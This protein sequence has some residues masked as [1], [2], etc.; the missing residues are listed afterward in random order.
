MSSHSFALTVV[1]AGHKI[2]Q[3]LAASWDTHAKRASMFPLFFRYLGCFVVLCAITCSARLE[4][5]PPQQSVILISVDT[6]RA[7]HLGCYGYRAQPTPNIDRLA[8]GGTLFGQASTQAPL[9][10]PSHVSLFTSRY[11]FRTQIQDNGEQLA[12]GAVTLATQFKAMGYRTAAFVG[13]FPLDRRFGLAQGFDVYDSPF[14]LRK[15]RGGDTGDIKRPAESVV[16]NATHWIEKNSDGPFFVFLHLYDLHTPYDLPRALQLRFHGVSYDSEL[17]YVD[18]TLGTFWKFLADR[19][20]FDRSLLIFTSDHGEGL[21]EHG[22]STHGYFIYQSTLHVPLIVHWPAD[23]PKFRERVDEPVELIQ[24]APTILQFAGAK[25]PLE[26]EGRVLPARA[27]GQSTP[28]DMPIYGESYYASRHFNCSPLRSIRLGA[29]KY[30]DA[31][32]PEL[33]DLGRDPTERRNIYT[34]GS[35]AAAILRKKLRQ[36]SARREALK[37]A[38]QG[39]QNQDAIAALRSLGYLAGGDSRSTSVV[40]GIDPKDRLLDFEAQNRAV[41]LAYSGRLQQSNAVLE[42]LIQ[43]LPDIPELRSSLGLNLQRLGRHAEAVRVFQEVV[44]QSESNAVAHFNLAVSYYQMRQ[45]EPSIQSLQKAL[46]IEPYYTRAE[47]LLGTIWSQKKDYTRARASFEHILKI[48]PD[49]Y[50]A[51]FNLGVLAAIQGKWD[52]GESHLR[53]VLQIDPNSAEAY[54][55]LGS[56]YLGRQDLPQA[57]AAFSDAIR[58]QPGFAWAHYNLGLVFRRENKSEDAAREFRAALDADPQFSAAH[59]ALDH[60]QRTAQ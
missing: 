17:A 8:S 21:G 44:K 41:L 55:A 33:Y 22:E 36:V 29:Y 16:Q 6:L 57:K 14:D 18:E 11:P 53:R 60:L 15:Q 4:A 49:D 34:P 38:P 9:T 43:K 56:L 19:G 46:E 27:M 3:L 28:D 37:P 45:L 50:A 20:L 23:S 1:P 7:D 59:T 32:K 26:M 51:H 30:I 25:V 12:P 35:S 54:N 31:P 42:Q 24:V 5:R 13:G 48:A 47:E 2:V 58:L 10:L 40:S 39:K 52:E